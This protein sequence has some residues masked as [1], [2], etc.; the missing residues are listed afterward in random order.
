MHVMIHLLSVFLSH[1]AFTNTGNFT[2]R[3]VFNFRGTSTQVVWRIEMCKK[4]MDGNIPNHFLWFSFVICSLSSAHPC[5]LN[6]SLITLSFSHS[7]ILSISHYQLP[8]RGRINVRFFY[9]SIDD[10]L[11]DTLCVCVCVLSSLS[12]SFSISPSHP[13]SLSLSSPGAMIKVASMS[14]CSTAVITEE[15]LVRE[16]IRGRGGERKG[17][18]AVVRPDWNSVTLPPSGAEVHV[19]FGLT[20]FKLVDLPK[21]H[22]S[23]VHLWIMLAL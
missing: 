11:H 18:A 5:S 3:F 13:H 23:S 16:G 19:S 8:V 15:R 7:F 6:N 22:Q 12:F 2:H 9:F 21:I 17:S 1:F 4:L 10:L 20:I 14:L